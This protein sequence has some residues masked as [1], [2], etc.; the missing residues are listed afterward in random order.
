MDSGTKGILHLNPIPTTT[1]HPA[2]LPSLSDDLNNDAEFSV[3]REILAELDQNV[4]K[5]DWPKKRPLNKYT[6]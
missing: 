2:N 5:L 1:P 6:V 3:L 4:T